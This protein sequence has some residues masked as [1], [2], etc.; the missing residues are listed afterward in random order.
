[1]RA[2]ETRGEPRG[3]GTVR[4]TGERE[5]EH[6]HGGGVSK[7]ET[8]QQDVLSILPRAKRCCK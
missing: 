8:Y 2:G 5:T 4:K 1:M 7:K 6:G 3:L